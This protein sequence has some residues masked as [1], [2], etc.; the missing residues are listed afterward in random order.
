MAHPFTTCS[1]PASAH[2]RSAGDEG[3]DDAELPATSQGRICAGS[4]GSASQ[5]VQQTSQHLIT[6]VQEDEGDDDADLTPTSQG[7]GRA[8]SLDSAAAA[9]RRGSLTAE[10]RPAEALG[11]NVGVGP[12]QQ[13]PAGEPQGQQPQQQRRPEAMQPEQMPLGRLRRGSASEGG[14][15]GGSRPGDYKYYDYW[16]M[17][18]KSKREKFCGL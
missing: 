2:H 3:D 7:R 11:S 1:K 16:L 10:S 5:N 14:P 17:P 15:G 13:Q 9:S 4:H 6:A 18:T 12:E 8:G